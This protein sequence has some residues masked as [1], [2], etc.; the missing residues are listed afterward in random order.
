MHLVEQALLDISVSWQARSLYAYL[1]ARRYEKP[2]VRKIAT[3]TGLRPGKVSLLI[4][5]LMLKGWLVRRQRKH[6]SH[7]VTYDFLYR[8]HPAL[9]PNLGRE[10]DPCCQ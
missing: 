4:S 10:G 3:D 7:S 9:R 5:E 6:G 1:L 8:G 2:V